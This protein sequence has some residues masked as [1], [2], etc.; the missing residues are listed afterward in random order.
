LP[1]SFRRLD[2]HPRLAGGDAGGVP[3]VTAGDSCWLRSIASHAIDRKLGAGPGRHPRPGAAGPL[4]ASALA[5][6]T[7]LPAA[8]ARIGQT[9]SP[10][11]QS[12][13]AVH[14]GPESIAG[15]YRRQAYPAQQQCA[16]V[17]LIFIAV[18]AGAPIDLWVKVMQVCS[19]AA[20]VVLGGGGSRSRPR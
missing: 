6:M 2:R 9:P 1:R 4:R 5:T 15:A 11:A 19:R 20:G 18:P 3:A 8:V 12:T 7:L 13:M 17:Y 16:A 14:P 10:G